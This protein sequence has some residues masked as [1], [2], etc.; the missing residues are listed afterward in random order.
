MTSIAEIR[1]DSE[2]KKCLEGNITIQIS[3]EADYATIPVY[4][5]GERPNTGLA[6][7]FIDISINGVIRSKT[8]PLGLFYG[9]LAVSVYCKTQNNGVVKE[10]RVSEVVSKLE[11]YL[12]YRKY[13]KFFFE[14]NPQ[15]LIT[16]TTINVSSGY[17]VTVL[18]VQ[19]RMFESE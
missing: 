12:K 11:E 7:E 2:L 15:N 3:E 14:L 10:Y 19:W 1:P 4:Q 5:H 16:P 9:N 13:G 6:D 18:N 8:K 17:S